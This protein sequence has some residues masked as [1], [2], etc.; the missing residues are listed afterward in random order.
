KRDFGLVVTR[1]GY[2]LDSAITEIDLR[3]TLG[4]I[5]EV[6]EATDVV[7]I[8]P[9]DLYIGEMSELFIACPMVAVSMRMDYEQ[10]HLCRGSSSQQAH[11]RISERHLA[12]ICGV[13][14]VN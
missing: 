14:R 4:P 1:C 3:E 6:V 12:W 7:T 2:H 10:V 5:G 9:N 11:P 13:A 8:K